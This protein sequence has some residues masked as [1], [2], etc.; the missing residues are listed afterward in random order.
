ME[1]GRSGTTGFMLVCLDG[2]HPTVVK[3]GPT[4]HPLYPPLATTILMDIIREEKQSYSKAW[5]LV[6][7]TGWFKCSFSA[8]AP[9]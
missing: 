7:A 9:N 4:Q 5:I 1:K 6:Q 8:I 3:H 2:G